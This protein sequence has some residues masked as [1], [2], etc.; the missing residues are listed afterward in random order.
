MKFRADH[1]TPRALRRFA[2]L[3]DIDYHYLEDI[4]EK[5]TI[6]A[7]N[8]GEKLADCLVGDPFA[9]FLLQGGLEFRTSILFGRQIIMEGSKHSVSM[10]NKLMP[11]GGDLVA[12]ADNT[13]I[14]I[15][16]KRYILEIKS[17]NNKPLSNKP[18][19]YGI[20]D[21]PEDFVTMN[22]SNWISNTLQ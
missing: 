4:Q 16:R 17:Q 14:L 11:K 12:A 9:Y 8:K 6:L 7:G 21:V 1:L 22:D 3:R 13:A 18:A 5:A 20:E 15:V 10:I 2:E 19:D